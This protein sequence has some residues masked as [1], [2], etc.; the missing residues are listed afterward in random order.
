MNQFESKVFN[1]FKYI[2]YIGPAYSATRAIVCAAKGN[3]DEVLKS[4]LALLGGIIETAISTVA[5]PAGAFGGAAASIGMGLFSQ[6][7]STGLIK[8]VKNSLIMIK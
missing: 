4:S 6:A 8:L 1:F 3:D 5:G 2:P 7:V